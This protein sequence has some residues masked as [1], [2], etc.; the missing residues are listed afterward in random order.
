MLKKFSF[1]DYVFSKIFLS[2]V[3]FL[4][5]VNTA[6]AAPLIRLGSLSIAQGGWG[7]LSLFVNNLSG[8][9]SGINAQLK[10]PPHVNVVGVSPGSSLGS[11]FTFDWE[12]ISDASVNG[13][14]L[15]AYS[16]SES[17]SQ[18]TL[19]L[20]I[21]LKVDDSCATGSYDIVFISK[22][23]NPTINARH[24]I[25]NVDGSQSL[26]H[27]T[28]SG[29]LTV[30]AVAQGVTDNDGDGIDDAW[31]WEH[32]KNLTKADKHTDFDGDGF[33]DIIEYQN[34][35]AGYSDSDGND[36]NP[37]ARNSPHRVYLD[38][39][40]GCGGNS[41]CYHDFAAIISDY[42]DEP[43]E[44]K[45][46]H[47]FSDS[48]VEIDGSGVFLIFRGGFDDGFASQN[49]ISRISGSLVLGNGCLIIERLELVG[50]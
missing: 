14:T 4:M 12:K 44:I 26:V 43:V 22:N 17:F 41:S 9:V 10:F 36:Y 7:E 48:D 29:T 40:G 42:P 20:Y 6:F 3:L 33:L 8:P 49:G 1:E 21:G 50:H 19:I 35:V 45:A 39:A 32:F 47:G 15:V 28:L 16:G 18:N 2:I 31:E 24:A 37:G 25:S 34:W 5:L 27:Q 38:P 23:I 13:V 11:S 46:R 30:T